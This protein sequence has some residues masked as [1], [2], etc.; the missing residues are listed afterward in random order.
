[1]WLLRFASGDIVDFAQA[2][3]WQR[4]TKNTTPISF[5]NEVAYD[6]YQV[7]LMAIR[8]GPG[9]W[10]N[11]MQIAEVDLLGL[12]LNAWLLSPVDGDTEVKRRPT[13]SWSAGKNTASVNGH[14]LYFSSDVNAVN[15]RIAEK[16]V[17]SEPSYSI[18]TKLDTGTTYYWCVDEVDADG[19]TRHSGDVWSFTVTTIAGR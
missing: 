6:H 9:Q 8:G 13:L 2:A 15:D 16:V 18:T 14:E 12:T 1:M 7:L 11:S 19:I 4:F 5:D 17:L 3:E 10:I